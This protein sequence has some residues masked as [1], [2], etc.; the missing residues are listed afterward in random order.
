MRNH[1]SAT[2]KAWNELLFEKRNKSYGAYELRVHYHSRL[3]RSL[4]ITLFSFGLIAG[5]LVIRRNEG[6][7]D[8]PVLHNTDGVFVENVEV[9]PR[10]FE[11]PQALNTTVPRKTI[12]E[13]AFKTVA[14]LLKPVEKPVTAI[15]TEPVDPGLT[16]M[17]SGIS[18]PAGSGSIPP[19]EISVR[20]SLEPMPMAA[21]D[22]VPEFPGG[23]QKFLDFLAKT[24][25]YPR[26][27]V[28]NGI[29]GRVYATFIINAH[30]E[31]ESV[32]IMRSLGF[33]LDEEVQRVLNLSPAWSPGIYHGKAVRT[34]INVPVSFQL[35]K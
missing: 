9:M 27:A 24:I 12:D 32:K 7:A 6:K 34:V 19:E 16:G 10:H 8:L 35:K 29:S 14:E 13:H 17:S 4:M 28:E 1:P 23:E 21:V 5:W 20:T 18:S 26:I 2:A 31:V 15:G 3:L 11:V 33:G 22:K 30:G 25:K